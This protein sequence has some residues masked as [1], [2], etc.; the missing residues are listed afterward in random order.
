MSKRPSRSASKS[1]SRNAKTATAPEAPV[2]QAGASGAGD[3]GNT[4]LYG[5]V[6]WPPPDR[7]EQLAGSGI[8]EPPRAVLAVRSGPIAALV[9][10]VWAAEVSDGTVRSLRRDMKAH[11]A[12]LNTVAA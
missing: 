8:G 12:V 2:P 3:Q 5:V 6:R 4:Y 1:K 9:S 11:S 10:H 7:L